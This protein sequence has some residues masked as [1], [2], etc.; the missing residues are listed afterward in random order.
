MR[1]INPTIPQC[2]NDSVGRNVVVANAEKLLAVVCGRCH[3][4]TLRLILHDLATWTATI[5]V[6]D[7]F[8]L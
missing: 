8:Q 6:E 2:C 1:N 7:L 4:E 3:F 5:A